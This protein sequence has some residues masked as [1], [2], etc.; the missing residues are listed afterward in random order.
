MFSCFLQELLH[1]YY[2]VY[3]SAWRIWGFFYWSASHM[4]K[5]F[6]DWVYAMA[7]GCDHEIVRALK[8]SSRRL[9]HE[10][11]KLN[12]LWS[13]AFKCSVKTYTWP[14]SQLKAILWP[15]YSCGLFPHNKLQFIQ[16]CEIS[17]CHGLTVS[18]WTQSLWDWIVT[19]SGR[20]LHSM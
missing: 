6:R 20:P 7:K 12:C 2:M 15:S 4:F 17:K 13:R 5:N 14:G 16:C 3:C 8:N 11:L 1:K 10:R 9:Y 19:N 18:C